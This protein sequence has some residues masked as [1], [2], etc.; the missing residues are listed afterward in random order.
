MDIWELFCGLKGI[1]QDKSQRLGVLSIREEDMFALA[2][3]LPHKDQV[4][5]CRPTHEG[6]WSGQRG[7]V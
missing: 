5:V 3:T 2:T 1:P 4:D 6:I 7:V